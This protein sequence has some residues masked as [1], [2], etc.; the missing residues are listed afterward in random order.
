LFRLLPRKTSLRMRV[1]V[2]CTML[3]AILGA[4]MA[5]VAEQISLHSEYL[6]IDEEMTAEMDI[7]IAQHAGDPDARLPRSPWKSLYI[8]RPG[9]PPTSPPAFRDLSPGVH[10]L[11]DVEDSDRFA[12][13]RI[14]PIGRVTMV[15][16]LP[17]SPARERRLAEELV[18]MILLGTVLGGWLGRM[19]AGSMLAPVL[20]L[21]HE[22]D[23]AEPGAELHRIASDHPA[24]EVGALA[25]ALIRYRDRMQLAI[26]RE[27]LFSADASHELRTPLC[28]L[29]GALDLLRESQGTA[30]PG[31]RRIE[32]MRRSAAE[33]GTLLDAL[34]LIARSDEA[35]ETPNATVELGPTLASV[36][37]EFR[38]ELD[39]AQITIQLRCAPSASLDAPPNLLRI[40]LRLLFRGIA[41]GAFGTHLRLDADARGL[42]LASGNPNADA[43]STVAAELGTMGAEGSPAVHAG[44]AGDSHGSAKNAISHRA[45]VRRSDETGGIGM[46]RRLC[47]RYGWAIELAQDP[48]ES[49][50]LNLRF[51]SLNTASTDARP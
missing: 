51:W 43:A 2:C 34:L 35:Q 26:E 32:R 8:D 16:G 46:L 40:A 12:A 24:D 33:I 3:G 36:I 22:V 21:S 45:D 10:E 41:S 7:Q 50:L 27:V 5:F 37:A 23:S 44:R 4:C 19:L 9:R 38:E 1:V 25:L 39:A 47:Q 13:I 18:A 30:A 28:V 17:S 31:Q 6:L 29:Q 11:D 49:I 20:R 42:V 15:A 48:A 14:A